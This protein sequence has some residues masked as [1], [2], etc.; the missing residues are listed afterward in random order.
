MNIL[1]I[2][3]ISISLAMDAFAVAVC[4]GLSMKKNYKN[5]VIIALYFGIFQSIMPLVGCFFGNFLYGIDKIDHFIAL[6]LLS[7]IGIS[8]ILESRENKQLD[9]KIDIKTM[10]LLSLATSIDAL[11]VGVT[12]SFLNVSIFLP[13]VMIGVITFF[14]SLFGVLIGSK[15]SIKYGSKAELLGGILLILIGIKIF[16][17]HIA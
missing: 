5:G 15:V 17:D 6:I 16:I 8:M 3:I 11:L 14:I 9:D 7:I 2:I 13:I 4:K 10:I 12:F 1:E